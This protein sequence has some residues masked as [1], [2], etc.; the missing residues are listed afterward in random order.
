[1]ISSSMKTKVATLTQTKRHQLTC[2]GHY[3][4]TESDR[5]ERRE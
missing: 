4:T 2:E 5:H 1:M 3:L